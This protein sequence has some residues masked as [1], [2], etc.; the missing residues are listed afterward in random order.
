LIG[1]DLEVR[2]ATYVPL[3]IYLRLCAHPDFWPEH[4]RRDL[5]LEF[6]DG[7][8]ADGRS[9][10]FHPDNWSF[11]Q[12][13]HASQ[14]IGRALQV[15]GV[16]RVLLASIKRL[17]GLSGPS[18]STITLAPG[19]VTHPVVEKLGVRPS[20]IIQVANDPSRL[21]TGRLNFEILGGR[22]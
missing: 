15:P 14:L 22:R 7:Y 2:P 3:D 10:F 6:S 1:E 17:H 13:F 11:G 4:L 9:G 8:T 16:G 18:L 21:E 12:S 5:E 20:E 19:D